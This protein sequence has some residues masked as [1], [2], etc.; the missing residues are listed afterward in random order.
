M[1]FTKNLN[2]LLLIGSVL[3]G[4]SI[5]GNCASTSI[6]SQIISPTSRS[7]K[8]ITEKSFQTLDRKSQNNFITSAIIA[9]SNYELIQDILQRINKDELQIPVSVDSKI[10]LSNIALLYTTLQKKASPS[11]IKVKKTDT[12]TKLDSNATAEI[13]SVE[14]SSDSDSS[15][16][17]FDEIQ[18]LKSYLQIPK[19]R[20]L[21]LADLHKMKANRDIAL[22]QIWLGNVSLSSANKEDLFRKINEALES[23]QTYVILGKHQEWN[24]EFGKDPRYLWTLMGMLHSYKDKLSK[25]I[26]VDK[27]LEALYPNKKE[28]EVILKNSNNDRGKLIYLW[29]L[30][31]SPEVLGEY[32]M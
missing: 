27:V 25:K 26:L 16:T 7:M 15:G 2:K 30:D 3:I 22:S 20:V 24:N 9:F 14:S 6:E 5:N 13:Q 10:M 28:R 32:I 21:S 18:Q 4:S 23:Y 1:S 8:T 17:D 12:S 19:S 29:L 31:N 11:E